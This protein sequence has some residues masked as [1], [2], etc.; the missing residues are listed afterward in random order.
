MQ[1]QSSTVSQNPEATSNPQ[2][3]VAHIRQMLGDIVTHARQ[4]IS[5]VHDPKAQ[6]LFETTAETLLGLMKAYEDY[7]RNMP[8]WQ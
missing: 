1:N 5:R 2:Y 4:D 8:E 6:A 3:H 7:E